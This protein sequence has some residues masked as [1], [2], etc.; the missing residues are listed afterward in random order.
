MPVVTSGR[1]TGVRVRLVPAFLFDFLVEWHGD[2]LHMFIVLFL[3][4]KIFAI[5]KPIKG[6][7]NKTKQSWTVY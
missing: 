2:W 3:W 4:L 6:P 7:T 1:M 5:N